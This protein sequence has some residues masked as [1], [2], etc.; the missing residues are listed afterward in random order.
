MFTTTVS[1][2]SVSGLQYDVQV[3]YLVST[4]SGE[5]KRVHTV[6]GLRGRIRSTDWEHSQ[7]NAKSQESNGCPCDW[8]TES[9]S[10]VEGSRHELVASPDCSCKNRNTPSDIVTCHG[11]RKESRG[12]GGSNQAKKAEN[13]GGKD[14]SPDG[15]EGDVSESL[16]LYEWHLLV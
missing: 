8:Q 7:T 1:E 10:S 13:D 15:A 11:Q 9:L 4:G 5:T 16:G 12:C 14:S 6:H 3:R 2:L